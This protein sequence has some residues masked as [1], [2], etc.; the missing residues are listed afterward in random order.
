M[1]VQRRIYE[2][3]LSKV[4]GLGPIMSKQLIAHCGDI[5][6]IWKESARALSAIPDINQIV[7]DALLSIDPKT[8]AEPDIEYCLKEGV[9]ITSCMDESYPTRFKHIP[10]API[11]Y[12]RRGSFD[13]HHKRTVAIVGT[14]KPSPYGQRICEEIVKDLKSYDVQIFSGMAYGI[15]SIAHR[16]ANQL[17]TENIAVMGTGMDVIYPANHRGLYSDIQKNGAIISEYPIKMRTDWENFPRRNRLIAALSDVI[18]VVQS[19]DKG[20][21]LI[22]ADFG[23]QYYKDVFAVPGRINDTASAGCN[24]LIKQ[25]EAHLY[26]SIDDIAYI[27]NW[28]PGDTK[29]DKQASLFVELSTEEQQIV[30]LIKTREEAGIDWI[31][32]HAKIPLSEL[33][34][35]LLQLEFQ[36]IVRPLPGNQYTL[37]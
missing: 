5:E 20:G 33:A 19:A 4:P 27:M 24:N 7:I 18:I 10:D 1:D 28:I 21:S 3:A 34:A 17:G 36:G 30:D 12:Y 14:R 32:H 31:H 8:L 26:Q 13:E 35:I 16:T 11:V 6:G 22:T 15:D 23:N 9:V 25:N 37:S 29:K 2:V